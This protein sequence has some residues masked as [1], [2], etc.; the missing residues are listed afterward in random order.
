MADDETIVIRVNAAQGE[1]ALKALGAAGIQAGK[2]VEKLG[3]SGKSITDK[4][5]ALGAKLFGITKIVGAAGQAIKEVAVATGNYSGATKDAIDQVSAL[6]QS[7][8][9]FDLAG[10]AAAMGQLAGQTAA[11]AQGLGEVNVELGNAVNLKAVEA[12]KAILKVQNELVASHREDI[13][14]LQTRAAAISR[15]IEVQQQNGDV[16]DYLKGK[17][18]EVLDAHEKLDV[19]VPGA[20]QRQASGL[21]VV[22]T[23][24]DRATEK[25]KAFADAHA[26]ALD[27]VVGSI[28]GESKAR[29]ESTALLLE[30]I[31][32]VESHGT[33]TVESQA[34]IQEA[35]QKEL[36]LYTQYGDQVPANLQAAADAYRVIAGE[37]E[38]VIANAAKII[39]DIDAAA[40]KANQAQ[41]A[42]GNPAL[43]ANTASAAKL[44]EEIKAIEDSP[45][46]TLEQQNNLDNLKNALLDTTKAARELDRSFTVTA[47]NY[48]T[49]E[50][51]AA[52]LAA[53][54][55][56]VAEEQRKLTYEHNKAADS[57]AYNDKAAA[58]LYDTYL[59]LDDLLGDTGSTFNDLGKETNSA[60][61]ALEKYGDAAEGIGDATK[62]GAEK[63][64]E[65]LDKMVAGFE[66]ALPLAKE[67]R[68]VLAEI[69]ALGQQADI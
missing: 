4:Y 6:T 40:V 46:I 33:V 1:A 50:E 29:K 58:D 18:K 31:K 44:K 36:A 45:F 32:V 14:A 39:A 20:L 22:S 15:E 8:A 42:N 25:V 69:V 9:S 65:G 27:K 10:A 60:A 19:F 34:K 11:W 63:G 59:G 52:K 16:S 56:I 37:Q 24:T 26:A 67:L 41:A 68:G 49:E 23:E 30:A 21:G 12:L 57:T 54:L 35:I 7:V 47:E 66:E 62:K 43:A 2:D 64:K 55:S 53:E 51:A 61:K 28:G 13:A 48:L 38:K 5:A 17:L 3:D